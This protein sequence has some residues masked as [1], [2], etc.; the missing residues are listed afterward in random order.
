MSVAVPPGFSCY[1]VTSVAFGPEGERIASGS[2]DETVRLW[3]AASGELLRTFEGHSDDV[4]SVAFGPDGERI[5]SGSW[6]ETIRLW[7]PEPGK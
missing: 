7:G 2:R 6:D 3:D 5:A 1:D 4:N